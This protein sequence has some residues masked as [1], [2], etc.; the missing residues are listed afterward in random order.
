MDGKLQD[1]WKSWLDGCCEG[2]W[3]EGKIGNGQYKR[4]KWIYY[5]ASGKVE[6]EVNYLDDLEAKS[7]RD[8]KSIY[9]DQDGNITDEDIYEN[10]VCVEM[11]EGDE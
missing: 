1:T 5:Y 9:Y 8:G 4:G 11:C 3:A 2:S 10:G 7:V 6:R